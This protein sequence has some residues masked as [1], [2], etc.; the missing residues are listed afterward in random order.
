AV[1]RNSRFFSNAERVPAP[2]L[3]VGANPVAP[4]LMPELVL[5][6]TGL[7]T[8]LV[9]V[10]FD[11]LYAVRIACAGIAIWVYRREYRSLAWKLH[12]DSI[13]IG[14]AVFAIWLA[15]AHGADARHTQQLA[16]A[17]RRIGPVAASAWI[18]ARVIGTTL[19]VPFVEEL[20]FRGYLL[21]RLVS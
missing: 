6:G 8:G 19:V 20:A 13:A 21:R 17:L 9:V 5:I 14:A 1:A 12:W 10:D 15:L 7:V 18:A 16:G 3:A 11:P 4:Y 2:T